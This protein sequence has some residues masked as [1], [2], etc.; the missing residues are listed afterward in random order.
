MMDVR[1]TD[2]AGLLVLTVDEC[3]KMLQISDVG[4]LA[5]L[6]DGEIEIFPVNYTVDGTAVAFRTIVGSKLAAA[7]DNTAVAF[8]ID[9]FD[10]ARRNG[11]SVV[12]KGTCEAIRDD[13]TLSR[14]EATGFR[15]W[16][17][18]PEQLR[19][20]RVRPHSITGR[21]IREG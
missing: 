3:A 1:A 12:I 17:D 4:R 7:L 11:W 16:I 8:E 14:L 21:Q 2:H 6:A 13:A 19:W 9:S 10:A 20:V 15:S 5:F 18:T